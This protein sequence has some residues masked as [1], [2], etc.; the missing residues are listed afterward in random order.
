[1]LARALL[2]LA[3]FLALFLALTQSQIPFLDGF[4][5]KAQHSAAFVA[6]GSL[7][8][9]ALPRWN[10]IA[11]LAVITVFGGAIELLQALPQIGR[12]AEWS[13]LVI[14]I[15]A[16]LIGLLIVRSNMWPLKTNG[17]DRRD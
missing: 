16:A 6:L 17:S 9:I 1:M 3:G 14:D 12:D 5:E 13:D 7:S 10:W 11:L 15:L 2:V 8:A 4:D